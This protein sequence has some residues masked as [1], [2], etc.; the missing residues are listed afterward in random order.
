LSADL[1][2][3]QEELFHKNR[4]QRRERQENPALKGRR[5]TLAAAQL[6]RIFC[7]F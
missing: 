7:S 6:S 4:R 2:S 5:F 1:T 3:D